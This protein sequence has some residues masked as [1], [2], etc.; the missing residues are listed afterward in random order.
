MIYA[1]QKIIKKKVDNKLFKAFVNKNYI[2][3]SKKIISNENK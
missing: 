1:N 3:H 2:Y